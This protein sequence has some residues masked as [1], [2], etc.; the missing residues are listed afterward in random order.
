MCLLSVAELE[1]S[2]ERQPPSCLP[3]EEAQR[4]GA[5]PQPLP[6]PVPGCHAVPASELDCCFAQQH[7][8]AGRGGPRDGRGGASAA[9]RH[10]RYRCAH[11]CAEATPPPLRAVHL[12]PMHS[13]GQGELSASPR[14]EPET[15]QPSLLVCSCE[16]R[17][18]SFGRQPLAQ[19]STPRRRSRPVGQTEARAATR[20]ER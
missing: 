8:S 20:P 10:A 14:L 2:S 17:D 16:Q 18:L 7:R 9:E 15:G 5:R 13:G 1:T 19:T 12:W 11:S 6:H 3:G 4:G